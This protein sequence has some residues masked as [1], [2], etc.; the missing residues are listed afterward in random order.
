MADEPHNRQEELFEIGAELGPDSPLLYV[1][2][3]LSHLPDKKD[4]ERVE[5]LAFTVDRAI[6]EE[7]QGAEEPWPIRIHSPIKLTAP[8]KEDD[9]SDGEIY[10]INSGKL[11]AEADAMILI[12]DCGGSLGMGQELEWACDLQI[13][14]LYVHPD[15]DPVSRQVKGATEEY[16]IEIVS[17]TDPADLRDKVGRWLT[18]RKPAILDG[19][20]RR[21]NREF[22]FSRTAKFFRDAWDALDPSRQEAI[23]MIARLKVA[24]IER[25][26]H[27]PQV[28]TAMSLQ[29]IGAL[30]GALGFPKLVI[31]PAPA[32]AAELREEQ[33]AALAAAAR[34]FGW[35]PEIVLLLQERAR[36]ELA[37]GGVR[38]LPLASIR[39]WAGL[40]RRWLGA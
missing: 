21:R 35:D 18:S 27:D 29:E 23:A 5:L 28:L 3:P 25:A 26:V 4:R 40:Y 10:R 19:P 17:Y 32:V 14:V 38:R 2:M 20:R 24:R 7:A 33:R 31:G 6:V 39:D 9:W 36:E 1:G 8:W 37:Q 30:R 12:A 15:E 13:P 11:W 34:E 22:I 16:D